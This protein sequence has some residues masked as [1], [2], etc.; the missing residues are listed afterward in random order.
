MPTHTREINKEKSQI[1]TDSGTIQ[2]EENNII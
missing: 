2:P 1:I